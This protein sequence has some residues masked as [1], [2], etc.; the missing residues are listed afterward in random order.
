MTEYLTPPEVAKRLRVSVAKV[1]HWIASGA[2]RATNVSQS[3]E[4]RWRVRAEWLETFERSRTPDVTPKRPKRSQRPPV[5]Y[6]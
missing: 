4:P 5:T 6:V 2:L 1:R 3:R